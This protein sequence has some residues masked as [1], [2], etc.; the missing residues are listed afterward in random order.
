MATVDLYIWKR[1]KKDGKFPISVRITIN[2]KPSY[3]MT[4]QKL[5]KLEQWDEKKQSVKSS[6]PNAVRLNNFLLSELAKANDKALE[7]ETKG[8]TSAKAVKTSLKSLEHK[9]IYFKEFADQFLQDQKAL[10]NYDT[11]RSEMIRIKKL[12]TFAGTD[13][14]TF[15]EITPEFLQRYIIFLRQCRTRR[16]NEIQRLNH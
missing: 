4:G 15:K 14:I 11:H 10:G 7:M 6:H 3:I 9:V 5:D 2:R 16:Y 12:Y 8:Q 13:K 1:P